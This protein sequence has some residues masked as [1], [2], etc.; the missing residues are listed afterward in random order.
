MTCDWEFDQRQEGY[1]LL[2]PEIQQMRSLARLVALR[3]RLAIVDGKTG[4]AM[5]W[6]ETGLVMG[7]HVSQGP[8]VIQA[9]VG[10]AIEA[11]LTRCLED[12][13]QAP[14]TPSLY[15]A[16][17]DRPRPFIDMRYPMEGERLRPRKRA[18]RAERARPGTVES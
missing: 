17:A 2:L 3:T 18:A 9:L 15:W 13:I 16:L 11:V 1:S 7:R 10:V 12:L 4:E 5:H 8:I 14:G 6:I